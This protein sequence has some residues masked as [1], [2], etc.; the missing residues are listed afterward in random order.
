[1]KKA[2]LAA[3]IFAAFCMPCCATTRA[4]VQSVLDDVYAKYPG[5]AESYEYGVW[6]CSEM[7]QY[8]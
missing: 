1:M 3:I 4:D 6:D 2:I 8:L 7:S 5:W